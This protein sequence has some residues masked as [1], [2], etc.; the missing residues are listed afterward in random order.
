M[1]VRAARFSVHSATWRTEDR[2]MEKL[3]VIPK[4]LAR[5]ARKMELSL[6]EMGIKS[7]GWK[8]RSSVLDM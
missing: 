4:F 5:L 2:G 6:T 8:N 3:R 1:V 7:G